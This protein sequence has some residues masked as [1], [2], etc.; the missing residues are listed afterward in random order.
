M[1]VGGESDNIENWFETE[2]ETPAAGALQRVT[3][4]E[5]LR[6]GD[7]LALIRFLAA[8]DVRTPARMLERL[9]NLNKIMP[10]LIADTLKASVR[11]MESTVRA[12]RKIPKTQPIEHQELFPARTFIETIPGEDGGRIHVEATVGRGLWLWTLKHALTKTLKSLY[13]HH[14]TILHCPDGWGWLTSDNPVVRLNYRNEKD[15]NFNGGWDSR[16]TEI[17]MPLSPTH[18]MYTQIGAK[19]IQGERATLY[20]AAQ[21]QRFTIE[22][23]HR[24][25]FGR[26]ADTQ[27]GLW[28]PRVIDSDTFRAEA[29]HWH[30]WNTQQSD[31]ES[32][33]LQ[34]RTKG[35]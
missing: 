35:S 6:P 8:Q 32:A 7:W 16:G 1:E 9:Q 26:T 11:K 2:F 10:Q 13:K 34:G 14:W 31:A 12:G 25:V 33:L 22:H 19:P 20:L 28:R 4:D 21:L 27:V 30:A 17:F 3:A 15:Y 29:A 18:L 23:A 5:E 24:Y